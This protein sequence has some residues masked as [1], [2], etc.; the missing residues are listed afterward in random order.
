MRRTLGPL[1]AAILW[2]HPPVAAAQDMTTTVGRLAGAW[3]QEDV[4]TLQELG[5]LGRGEGLDDRML[6]VKLEAI[7]SPHVDLIRG[8]G[9]WIGIVLKDSAGGARRFCEALQ[10][11]GILCK[12]T[13]ENVI[14]VAPPLT[15][16]REEIDWAA[17]R[18]EQV[19]TSI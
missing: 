10:R 19:L 13:H 14:R 15:V 18:F 2:L 12:E 6:A 5:P 3:S 8:K 9:L 7:D 1:V 17:E 11:V 16:T 4:G